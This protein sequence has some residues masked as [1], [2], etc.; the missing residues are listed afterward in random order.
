MNDDQFNYECMKYRGFDH[1]FYPKEL[2]K[3]QLWQT[4]SN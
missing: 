4:L 2:K 3:K 1:Y